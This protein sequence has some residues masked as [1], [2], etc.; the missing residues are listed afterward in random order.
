[1][2]LTPNFSLAEFASKDGAEFPPQVIENLTTLAKALQV[3]RDTFKAKITINSGYR[4]P[5]HNRKIGG[6][7]HSQHVRGT[8]ADFTVSGKTPAEVAAV[9]ENL[10]AHGKIPQGG[11]KAY[12]SWVHYDVRGERARW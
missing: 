9:I 5:D 12:A 2:K 8:A 11:L 7:Q 4:S 3:I 1:M 6:A 10:I